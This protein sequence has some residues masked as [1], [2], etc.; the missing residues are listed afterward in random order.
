MSQEL[1]KSSWFNRTPPTETFGIFTCNFLTAS[2]QQAYNSN[3][4]E[5]RAKTSKSHWIPQ[6]NLFSNTSTVVAQLI[7]PDHI[8]LHW[9]GANQSVSIHHF[10]SA[11]TS[12]IIH[13]NVADLVLADVVN[14]LWSASSLCA[15]PDKIMTEKA[16][17]SELSHTQ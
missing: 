4:N 14:S 10:E 7:W 15:T 1:L 2:Y 13:C 9:L 17:L 8:E 12:L 6:D 3:A 16:S 5:S 11:I